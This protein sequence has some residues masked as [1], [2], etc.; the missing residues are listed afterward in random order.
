MNAAR[1]LR[2][3]WCLSALLL[4]AAPAA[5]Q[6]TETGVR[7]GTLAAPPRVASA[8]LNTVFQKNRLAAIRIED[9]PPVADDP[10]CKE[11]D[12]IGSG[13]LISADGSALT[14][15]HVVFGATRLEAVT[16]NKKR[17]QVSVVGFD[18][19]HDLALL[20]INISGAAFVPLAAQAPRVGQAALAIGNAG[21]KFLQPKTGTLLALDAAAGRADFPPG[22]LQLDAPLAPGDSG[23][24]ILNEA[25]QLIGITSYIRLDDSGATKAGSAS[26][27]V[28]SYA[29]PVTSGSDLLAQLRAGVK[30]EAP[31]LG[32][33]T[34]SSLTEG[35]TARFFS[36][37]GLG[38][39]V[40]Y[41]FTQLVKGGPADLAGL[42]PLVATTFDDKGVPTHA[43]G[44]VITAVDAQ[45]VSDYL[46][47]L[48]AIR[49]H[50][51][52][53]QVTLTVFRDGGA[54]PLSIVVT[55]APR[56]VSLGQNKP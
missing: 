53:D 19:Q 35:L 25:G 51:V 38:N 20:K 43:T 41:V 54:K 46:E 10:T 4:L 48:A 55:L 1:A 5:G 30:R 11:P 2:P 32:I 22:T 44:D 21:G 27:K 56:T 17:Y 36:D 18:E 52:G 34:T 15:Y 9:C 13:V 26:P 47:F 23:G 16:L 42:H 45:P 37:L 33:T 28:T 49:S 8:A 31:I 24:P 39:R 12:G 40:G 14:A 29:V 50:Q 6:N 3:V 7:A